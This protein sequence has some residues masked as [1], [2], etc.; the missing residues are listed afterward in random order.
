MKKSVV[1][2]KVLISNGIFPNMKGFLY[3]CE[4]LQLYVEGCTIK[5]LYNKIAKI[6]GVLPNSV[7]KS[8]SNSIEKAFTR[9]DT[10]EKYAKFC[11]N[12]GKVSN[13][14]FIILLYLQTIVE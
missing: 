6:H 8:I 1:I 2:K 7:E 11:K 5:D 14:K 4:L 12:K 3:C 13:K 10:V 9:Y